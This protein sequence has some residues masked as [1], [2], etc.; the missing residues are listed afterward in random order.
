[1]NRDLISG[2]VIVFCALGFVTYLMLWSRATLKALDGKKYS[3]RDIM[4]KLHGRR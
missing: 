3:L 4:N 1:M 2:I